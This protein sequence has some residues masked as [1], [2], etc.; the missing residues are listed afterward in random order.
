MSDYY[1]FDLE[2]ILAFL[3]LL[4]YFSETF[5]IN[6]FNSVIAPTNIKMSSQADYDKRLAEE[7]GSLSTRLVTAVNKQVELEETILELR[8]QV[9]ALK[10]K[11]EQLNQSDIK[12]KPFCPNTSS[13]KM[14]IEKH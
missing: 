8:K 7:V 9:S 5:Q 4:E 10:L 6:Q 2:F 13:Y 14:I 12:L 11:N 1:I 3:F